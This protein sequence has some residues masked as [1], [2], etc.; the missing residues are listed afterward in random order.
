MG[1]VFTDGH[2]CHFI[3]Q[4]GSEKSVNLL[5]QGLKQGSSD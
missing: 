5:L 2:E 4:D 3:F 1:L